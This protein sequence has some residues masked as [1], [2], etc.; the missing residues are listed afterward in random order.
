[1][2]KSTVFDFNSFLRILLG[3][4]NFGKTKYM[5]L[6]SLVEI[7][8]DSEVLLNDAPY[9]Y[10]QS[11]LL[12]IY[13]GKEKMPKQV[14]SDMQRSMDREH[15]LASLK[16][17]ISEDVYPHIVTKLYETMKEDHY[18]SESN[19]EELAKLLAVKE[20]FYDNEPE[21][22]IY[23]VYRYVVLNEFDIR[24]YRKQLTKMP[25]SNGT[26]NVLT[27][28]DSLSR[29]Q[30]DIS[31]IRILCGKAYKDDDLIAAENI[32]DVME[33]GRRWELMS[34]LYLT[35]SKLRSN[36]DSSGTPK[37]KQAKKH[38]LFT[39][40]T[41]IIINSDQ[42]YP[43]NISGE[44]KS[45]KTI[46]LQAL[47][48]HIFDLYSKNKTDFFPVYIDV[49]IFFNENKK[50]DR[51]KSSFKRAY[52]LAVKNNSKILFLMDG[53]SS[54]TNN[55][56]ENQNRIKANINKL[57]TKTSRKRKDKVKIVC[58]IN[59]NADLSFS[60][61]N[62]RK[63]WPLNSNNI[64]YINKVDLLDVYKDKKDSLKKFADTY[65][66]FRE[67]DSPETFYENLH[68]VDINRMS[69]NFIMRFEEGL[70]TDQDS[71]DIVRLHE[72]YL[73][74]KSAFEPIYDDAPKIAFQIYFEK[75]NYADLRNLYG[76]ALSY[77]AYDMLRQREMLFYLCAKHYL[78]T[79]IKGENIDSVTGRI[80]TKN[81]TSLMLNIIGNSGSEYSEKIYEFIKSNY[82]SVRPT[83]LTTMAFLLGRIDKDKVSCLGL[84]S[85]M[86]DHIENNESRKN[87]EITLRTIKLAT[88]IKTPDQNKDDLAEEY[89]KE[90][91]GSER[92]R[93]INRTFQRIY[94][95]DELIKDDFDL[96]TDIKDSASVNIDFY[97]SFHNIAD[98]LAKRMNEPV[99]R[100]PL[101]TIDLLT[102]C[103]LVN[104]RSREIY[105]NGSDQ[106]KA[107]SYFYYDSKY[108]LETLEVTGR[109]ISE[110][111][112]LRG[113]SCEHGSSGEDTG[114][115]CFDSYLRESYRNIS[116]LTSMDLS[117]ICRSQDSYFEK[118]DIDPYL[119]AMLYLPRNIDDFKYYNKW[120]R[121]VKNQYSAYSKDDI[122]KML[123][124]SRVRKFTADDAGDVFL[125]GAVSGH[126]DLLEYYDL[127]KELDENA[128]INAR[129]ASDILNVRSENP[130][131]RT[132]IGKHIRDI[133]T[134]VPGSRTP[135]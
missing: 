10:E 5:A 95:G 110:Y 36:E 61:G 75:K 69:L 132:E 19:T 127:L 103:D 96:E 29:S 126:A 57:I 87:R 135:K 32:A 106:E 45:G 60:L 46:F 115:N 74:E 47:Y 39:Q 48:Y 2:D 34:D 73:R 21:E 92:M 43:L 51:I 6:I 37:P 121:K 120:S 1:M 18:L 78:D 49:S 56:F 109:L 100:Y 53:I 9:E 27:N 12:K 22:F 50:N 70:S 99:E 104:S 66:K 82:R 24:E 67:L 86:L 54:I 94:Y 35:M 25:R 55:D 8:T 79:L 90:L 71:I 113:I 112:D 105:V 59:T 118:D 85:D 14:I 7:L 65:I 44:Y 91:T 30:M 33:K 72:D 84:L 38:D 101:K 28:I 40:L 17:H 80:Y 89:L 107:Y 119:L 11:F 111:L 133:L 122:I 98:R 26:D 68:K 77:K 108:R 62:Q 4:G 31:N 129:I 88:L 16:D 134:G 52:K 42:T 15:I 97:Y 13:N 114:E 63:N 125:R 130:A 116:R 20:Q 93:F 81:I 131:V 123:Q 41:N 76:P 102:L 128:G 64:L 124:I 3:S 83:G 117:D 58:S 23:Q